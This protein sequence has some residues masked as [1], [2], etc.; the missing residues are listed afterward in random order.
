MPDELAGWYQRLPIFALVASRLA[1]AISYHPVLSAINV[2]ARVRGLLV[3]G[4]AALVTP[5]VALPA[6]LPETL[7]QLVA[8]LVG[9]ALLGILL[10]LVLRTVFVSL[11]LAGRMISQEAGLAFGE[12]VDPSM[13]TDETLIGVFYSQLCMA[14]FLIL[15]GHRTLMQAT[16]GT[17]QSIPLLSADWAV[18]SDANVLLDGLSAALETSV[19]I[20]APVLLALLLTNLA[21]GFISRTVPQLNILT[22]GFA[23]KGLLA[24]AVMT[25]ALPAAI[26]TFLGTLERAV[27]WLDGL[28]R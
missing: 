15:G 7:A 26:D 21:M 28:G 25:A 19:R 18:L 17:F 16:L 5:M 27:G 10:G 24:F 8:A 9:E 1:G 11:Q 3:I 20:A 12:L 14:V 6:G 22:L 13:G 23:I 2:P 4:L